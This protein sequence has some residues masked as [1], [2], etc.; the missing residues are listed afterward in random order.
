VSGIDADA[1][2]ELVAA[3]GATLVLYARQWCQCPDDAVQEAFVDLVKLSPQPDRPL[4]WLFIA[5]R[6]RAL[7]LA[8]SERRREKRQRLVAEAREPWFS[9]DAAGRLT[10]AEVTALLEQLDPLDR[11]IVVARIWGELSFEEVVA[12]VDRPLSTVH[13][14]Y[15][16]ALAWLGERI[17]ADDTQAEVKR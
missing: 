5:A 15:R 3:H 13:R 14:R 11:E 1:V 16:Q 6:R 7:N 8:R 17:S 10:A 4:A 12:V 2:R 9:D